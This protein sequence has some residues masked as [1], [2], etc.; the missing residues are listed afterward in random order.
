MVLMYITKSMSGPGVYYKAGDVFLVSEQGMIKVEKTLAQKGI[1]NAVM[2]FKIDS[3]W[4]PFNDGDHE[5]MLIIRTGGIGD[6]IALSAIA[7]YCSLNTIKFVTG[8]SMIPIFKWYSCNNIYPK[9]I[10]EPIYK[11]FHPSRLNIIRNNSKRLYAEGVIEEGGTQNWY[12]VFFGA[13]GVSEIPEDLLRPQLIKDRPEGRRHIPAKEKS[14]L[15]CHRASAPMRTMAVKDIYKPLMEIIGNANIGIYVHLNNLSKDDREFLF[16]INDDR[17]RY[18]TAKDT[19]E[20]LLDLFDA[21]LTISVDT[22][23]IHFRE[24]VN[25]PGIG[26]YSSFTSDSRTKHYKVTRSFDLKTGCDMQPCFIHQNSKNHICPK[27]QQGQL[28]APCM[29]K[30]LTPDIHQQIIN[31]TKDYIK[32]VLL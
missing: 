21:T 20:Y 16:N 5:E 25:K 15:I 3:I 10:D 2:F 13:I 31:Q 4:N 17:L 32:D 27:A 8:K 6:I 7:E 1:N 23:A 14:V 12:E 11:G 22:A 26:I 9:S 30:E 29:T 28:T 24:G 18:L 19:H